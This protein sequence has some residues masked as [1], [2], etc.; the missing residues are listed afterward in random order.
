[1]SITS[2]PRHFWDL[3]ALEAQLTAPSSPIDGQRADLLFNKVIGSGIYQA[4]P[5]TIILEMA[6]VPGGG[7]T[8][9]YPNT[10]GK[11][12]G[13]KSS[14]WALV[15]ELFRFMEPGLTYAFLSVKTLEDG[16]KNLLPVIC[17]TETA[18]NGRGLSASLAAAHKQGQGAFLTACVEV[19]DAFLRGRGLKEVAPPPPVQSGTL[20]F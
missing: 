16:V 12:V 11:I 10:P 13:T 17:L 20:R 9:S 19:N 3:S 14:T 2:A 8:I 15:R 6:G 5:L 7:A 18:T 4:E 1:M